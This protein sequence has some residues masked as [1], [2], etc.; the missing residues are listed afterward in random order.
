MGCDNKNTKDRFLRESTKFNQERQV[1]NDN[2]QLFE[3]QHNWPKHRE[4]RRLL[5]VMF[6]QIK[7]KGRNIEYTYKKPFCYFAKCNLE[8]VDEIVNFINSHIKK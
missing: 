7:L 2:L 8:N 6:E 4:K 5:D 3:S 1:K